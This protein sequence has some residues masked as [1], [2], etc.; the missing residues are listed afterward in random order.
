MLTKTNHD[1]EPP[2]TVPEPAVQSA[3][4][5][6]RARTADEAYRQ[7]EATAALAAAIAI[8]RGLAGGRISS[9]LRAAL[10]DLSQVHAL[11][12]AEGEIFYAEGRRLE[13]MATTS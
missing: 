10:P 11:A 5:L 2:P 7:G 6:R 9:R 12:V 4:R 3:R 8:T 1:R 13:A